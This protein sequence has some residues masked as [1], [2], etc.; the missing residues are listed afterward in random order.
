LKDPRTFKDQKAPLA[1][2]LE[3][4]LAN[5]KVT[6]YKIQNYRRP[7]LTHAL[8]PFNLNNNAYKREYDP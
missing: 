8:I 1:K 3:P 7:P 5:V 4:R 2:K 6:H